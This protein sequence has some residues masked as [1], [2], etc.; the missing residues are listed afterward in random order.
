MKIKNVRPIMQL[1]RVLKNGLE[2]VCAGGSQCCSVDFEVISSRTGDSAGQ[3]TVSGMVER[4]D[5]QHDFLYWL[6]SLPLL[7]GDELFFELSSLGV[8]SPVARI[9]TYEQLE[10]LRI[11]CANAEKSGEIDSAHIEPPF[12]R[13][14]RCG[15]SLRVPSV[16]LD[17]ELGDG[18]LQAVFCR[19][20][21][22]RD[23]KTTEWR[24]RLSANTPETQL[25]G[26][27][28]SLQGGAYVTVLA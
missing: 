2:L 1:L 26:F 9:Y 18:E 7:S 20:H 19:G 27:W 22:M 8:P 5:G 23:H 13:R 14:Q 15:L 16:E 6:E 12:L 28:C 24:L 21:W 4:A 25:P 10:A 3:L 17:G 11:E